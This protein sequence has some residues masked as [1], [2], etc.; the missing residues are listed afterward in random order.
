[1]VLG[2]CGAGH[3]STAELACDALLG[4]GLPASTGTK[5]VTNLWKVAIP[6]GTYRYYDG[7]LYTLALLHVSGTFHLWY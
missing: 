2:V 1:M 6:T 5:F 3:T 7:A 4:F